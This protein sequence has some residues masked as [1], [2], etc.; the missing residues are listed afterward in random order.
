MH[1]STNHR[2]HTQP[3]PPHPP[4]QVLSTANYPKSPT[5]ANLLPFIG[6]K[7]LLV[8]EPHVWRAHRA[9]FNPGFAYSFLK[10]GVG[11]TDEHWATAAGAG[12][13]SEQHR[14]RAHALAAQFMQHALT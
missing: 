12:A 5:Y 11:V 9:A 10:V 7:S 3:L 4:T 1:T 6:H 13:A 2:T 8:A 14:S